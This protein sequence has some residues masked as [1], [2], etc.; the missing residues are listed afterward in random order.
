MDRIF[1]SNDEFAKP[2]NMS[3]ACINLADQA[4]YDAL[5]EAQKGDGTK[6][7]FIPTP[8]EK[9]YKW[10]YNEDKTLVVREKISDGSFRW[11]WNDYNFTNPP[12]FMPVPDNL[13][14]FIKNS[15]IVGCKISSITMRINIGFYDNTIRAWSEDLSA[16][17]TP[18]GVKCIME[19]TDTGWGEYY[20]EWEEPTFNPYTG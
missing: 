2:S 19:S 17:Y 1:Y 14:H 9:Q 11:Y 10:Y 4:T 16:N 13:T 15:V 3:L 18:L 6:I 12:I 7:Y 20:H 5:T 8:S